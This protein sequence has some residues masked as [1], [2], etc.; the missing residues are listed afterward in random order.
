MWNEPTAKQLSELPIFYAT[1]NIPL[2]DK[3]VEMHFFLGGSD[4]YAIE[5]SP[6]ENAFFGYA[7]LGNDFQSAEWGYFGYEELRSIQ[8]NSGFEVDR[9]LY[10][11]PKRA[12]DVERISRKE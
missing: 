2:E 7:V 9:D 8:M 5:Y 1:E 12:G 4:W 10:W 11:T 6:E 3:V